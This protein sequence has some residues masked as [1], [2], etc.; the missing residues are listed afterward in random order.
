MEY[1]F[2]KDCDCNKLYGGQLYFS[3]PRLLSSQSTQSFQMVIFSKM[4][5]KNNT[6]QTFI[7]VFDIILE[8]KNQKIK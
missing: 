3:A 8:K 1:V 5:P 7:L 2:P 4:S 6:V